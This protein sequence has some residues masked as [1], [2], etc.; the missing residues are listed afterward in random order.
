MVT[1]GTESLM[2]V[3]GGREDADR[4][5]RR[6]ESLFLARL[7]PGSVLASE[8]GGTGRSV[9]VEVELE[10]VPWLLFR[11]TSVVWTMPWTTTKVP[12][13]GNCRG[14]C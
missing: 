6:A 11:D 8:D 2:M 5:L 3:D 12:G 1:E 4:G 9:E 10:S 13:G 14:V 7:V